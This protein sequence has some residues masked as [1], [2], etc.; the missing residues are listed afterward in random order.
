MHNDQ[1]TVK[2]TTKSEWV[3]LQDATANQLQQAAAWNHHEWMVLK[4]YAA[5]GEVHQTNGVTW[6]YAPGPVGESMIL[7]PQLTDAN[8]G[9][10]LDDIV[11]YYLDRRP[12]KSVGCWSLYPT[13]PADLG[14]RLLARGFQ[15]GWRP[16]WMWLDL[17]RMRTDHPEPDGLRIELIEGEANW[18]VGD[19]PYYSRETESISCAASRIQPQRVWRFGAWLNGNPVG[20][21]TL[22]LTTGPLGTAGLYDVG[23]V[24]EARNKGVGKAVTLVACLHAQAMGCRHALLNGTG[25]RMYRQVGFE[26]IG[27]GRTWWLNLERLE[28]QPATRTQIDFAEALGRGDTDALDGLGKQAGF[29]GFDIPLPCGMTP[30]QLAVNTSQ[31]ASAKWLVAHGATLDVISAWALDWK[32]RVPQLLADAPELANARFGEERMAPLHI[33]AIR[34]DT[35]LARA[36]L[37]VGPDLTIDNNDA[38]TPLHQAAWFGHIDIVNL[39]LAHNPPLEVLNRYG[40]TPLGTTIHGSIHC[41]NRDGDYVAVVES[42]IAAGASVPAGRIPTGNEAI[43]AI[44]RRHGAKD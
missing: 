15:L 9:E 44:L 30:V 31:P 42:L 14:V 27:Y 13:Q 28:F 17:Q 41:Q 22:C 29:E 5:G 16:R 32:D 26:R 36:L 11:Q 24:P 7:F 21:S 43:D 37:A 4:A 23:V 40:G 2:R 12:E 39:L 34:N 10:H 20:H 8:A 6:T 33:A 1:E 18:D 35:E 25:E 38:G 19:L 3:F